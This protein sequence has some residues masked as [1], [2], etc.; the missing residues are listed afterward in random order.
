M[1]CFVSS[2]SKPQSPRRSSRLNKNAGAQTPQDILRRSLRNNIREVRKRRRADADD[3][4]VESLKVDLS[5][6]SFQS[7]TRK[8]LPATKRRTASV[9]LRKSTPAPSSV[10]FDDGDTPRHILRNILLTGMCM[11]LPLSYC[12]CYCF[13]V[14]FNNVICHVNQSLW[15]P[16]WF[17]RKLYQKSHSHL[18][19]TPALPVSVQGELCVTCSLSS[20]TD[21]LYA[22]GWIIL[23]MY[24]RFIFAWF[25]ALSYQGWTCLI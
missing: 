10:L 21:C 18:Q 6:S 25:S 3:G 22:T 23:W 17:M 19:P 15:S 1:I 14:L 20:N 2:A 24:N 12:C 11:G 4:Y 16:L 7:I 5:L 13:V 8:S 9:V